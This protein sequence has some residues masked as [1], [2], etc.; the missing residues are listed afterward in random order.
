MKRSK[1]FE[2]NGLISCLKLANVNEKKNIDVLYVFE[3]LGLHIMNINYIPSFNTLLYNIYFDD[4]VF[5]P[6]LVK[7]FNRSTKILN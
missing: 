4:V 2:A 5:F 7:I 3:I 6:V 1:I